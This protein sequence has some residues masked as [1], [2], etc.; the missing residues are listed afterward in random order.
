M[1]FTVKFKN[2]IYFIILLM[3]C[4]SLLTCSAAYIIENIDFINVFRS[5]EELKPKDSIKL[6]VIMYHIISKS[7]TGKYI[8]KPTQLES[9][10]IYLKNNNFNTITIADLINYVH[11]DGVL[12]EKPV[13]ITFDDGFVNNLSYGVPLLE[14]Y[15]MKAVFSVVGY[16][17]EEYSKIK[18]HNPIYSYFNWD[19]VKKLLSLACVEIQCHSYNMHKTGKRAGANKYAGEPMESY[20]KIFS[21][22]ISKFKEI[23]KENV[24]YEATAFTYPFGAYSAASETVIKKEG[25]LSSLTCYEIINY[26]TK[27]PACLYE[28]GRF[29]RS[30]NIST[31]EF[32]KRVLKSY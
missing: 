16:Y 25:F 18:D 4:I 22:D 27:D 8:I 5:G 23:M 2:K 32:F 11:G 17:I 29:N 10:L 31:E 21:D 9:D 14:K 20:E 15:N 1:F 6:P 30:G 19:D 12:P 3:L 28:L 24:D 26:I 7:K 13:I